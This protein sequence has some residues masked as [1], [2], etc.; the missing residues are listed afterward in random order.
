MQPSVD[1]VLESQGEAGYGRS[2]E[3][4]EREIYVFD[5]GWLR[6]DWEENDG[7]QREDA[8]V[9]RSPSTRK[10]GMEQ[11]IVSRIR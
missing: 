11:R 9:R 8:K 1:Q 2:G 10:R 3:E 7:V 4:E 5:R 6:Y